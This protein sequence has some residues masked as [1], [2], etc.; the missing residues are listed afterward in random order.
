MPCVPSALLLALLS[1]PAG[2]PAGTV[3]VTDP[4]Y[5]PLAEAPEGMGEAVGLA[6]PGIGAHLHG[7]SLFGAEALPRGHL[8]LFGGAGFPYLTAEALY[9]VSRSWGLYARFD[10]LYSVMEQVTLGAKWTVA[11]TPSGEALAIRFEA[12]QSFFEFSE[13]QD[14]DTG[15]LTASPDDKAFSARWITGQRNEGAAANLVL[16]TRYASGITLFFDGGLDFTVDTEPL[17]GGPLSGNP[18]LFT[19]GLNT[20][21]HV[22]L[23]VPVGNRFNFVVTLGADLHF[24]RLTEGQDSIAI[25]FFSL[26]ADGLL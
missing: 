14:Q 24:R 1:A 13:A 21:L 22:G 7:M 6:P 20:P 4:S 10:S 26:G 2:L 25:P 19:L 16:S 11:Q 23:E 8:G 12:N 18:P 9:G 3:D 5:V 17:A 15:N